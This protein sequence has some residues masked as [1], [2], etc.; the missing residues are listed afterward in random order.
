MIEIACRGCCAGAE[1]SGTF[2]ARRGRMSGNQRRVWG[3]EECAV[4]T[5]VVEELLRLLSWRACE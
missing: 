1:L 4:A 2:W 5:G 3:P